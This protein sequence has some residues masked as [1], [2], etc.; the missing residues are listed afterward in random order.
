MVVPKVD[1]EFAGSSS[2]YCDVVSAELVRGTIGHHLYLRN[3]APLLI[4]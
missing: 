3:R 2:G 1:E 4:L